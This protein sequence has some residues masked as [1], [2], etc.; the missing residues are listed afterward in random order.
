M[1][2]CSSHVDNIVAMVVPAKRPGGVVSSD[3]RSTV[4][5]GVLSPHKDLT[6]SANPGSCICIHAVGLPGGVFTC[7]MKIFGALVH[8]PGIVGVE[9]VTVEG[10]MRGLEHPRK[11]VAEKEP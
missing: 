9:V 1:V 7:C 6:V 10:M 2:S 5:W 11:G 4:M 3:E 8:W